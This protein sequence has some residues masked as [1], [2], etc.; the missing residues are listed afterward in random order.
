M[1]LTATAKGLTAETEFNCGYITYGDFIVELVRIAYGQQF[2]ESFF[3]EA[4]LRIEMPQQDIGLWNRVCNPAL[5]LLIFHSDTDG[6]VSWQECRDIYKA[7][8][9]LK[10]EMTGHNYGVMKIYNMFDH[11]KNIFLHCWKHRVTL[12]YR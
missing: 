3:C 6:K 7:M 11:W 2:A 10:S 5:D 9:P 12:W 8:L 1:G 4:F